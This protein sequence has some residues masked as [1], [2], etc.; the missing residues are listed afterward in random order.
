MK[1]RIVWIVLLWLTA[2]NLP[3]QATQAPLTTPEADSTSQTFFTPTAIPIETLLALPTATRVPTATPRAALGAPNA[4]AVNCR[5]GPTTAY[6][7]IGILDSGRQAEIVGKNIDATWWYARNPRDPST[8][9]WLIASLIDVAGNV[10][11]L[12]VVDTPPGIVSDISVSIDPPSLNV[13]CTSFPHYVTVSAEITT[14]GPATVTWRWETS[15]GETIN[16]DGLLFFEFGSQGVFTT[17]RINAARDY[18]I[19]LHVLSPNDRTSRSTFKA[20]CVP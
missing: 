20:T 2:C 18:W 10:E 3:G 17:Y 13:G 11:A 9:C 1:R 5:Y 12:P 8:F 16:G 7:V 6:A 19:Q 4:Q 15:A 14:N